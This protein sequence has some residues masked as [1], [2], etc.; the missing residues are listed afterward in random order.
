[1]QMGYGARAMEL[2]EKYYEGKVPSL[3]ENEEEAERQVDVVPSQVAALLLLLLSHSPPHTHI[4]LCVV[5]LINSSRFGNC[6]Y[7]LCYFFRK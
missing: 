6:M 4:F 1:M 2:L 3:V 7:S 5:H